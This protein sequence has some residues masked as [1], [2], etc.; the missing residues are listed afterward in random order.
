M[1]INWVTVLKMVPWSEVISNAPKIAEGAKNLWNTVAK[2]PVEIPDSTTEEAAHIEPMDLLKSQLASTEAAVS[3]LHT[4][5]LESSELIKA[6]A[7]QNT[8]LVRR[9]EANRVRVI[10]L[11]SATVVLIIITTI[12]LVMSF[13][14]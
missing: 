8:E 5:M 12:N 10:W 13:S 11:G 7:E 9:V 2:K 14:R 6:L 1:A 3:E 4:Q